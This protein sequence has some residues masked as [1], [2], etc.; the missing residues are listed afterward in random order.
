MR[1]SEKVGREMKYYPLPPPALP[2]VAD[3]RA[4]V[5]KRQ[6]EKAKHDDGQVHSEK[7][8]ARVSALRKKQRYKLQPNVG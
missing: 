6:L 3:T 1:A 4:G 8:S 5:L 7:S 2:A